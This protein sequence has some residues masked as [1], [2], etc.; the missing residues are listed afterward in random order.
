MLLR[1]FE[2]SPVPKA[3]NKASKHGQRIWVG[4]VMKI[5][6]LGH[7]CSICDAVEELVWNV[8]EENE[9]A[10]TI[11]RVVKDV[12]IVKFGGVI[13]PAVVVGNEIKVMGRKP[14]KEEVLSWIMAETLAEVKQLYLKR[15]LDDFAVRDIIKEHLEREAGMRVPSSI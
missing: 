8:V 9:I 15:G 10:A 12:N 3:D 7:H 2:Y 4:L 13:T 1:R 11:K 5:Y 14:R 6:I